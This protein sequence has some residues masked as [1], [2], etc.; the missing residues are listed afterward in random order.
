MSAIPKWQRACRLLIAGCLAILWA[1]HAVLTVLTIA[2]LNPASLAVTRLL[3][4]YMYP[5]FS[6]RWSLFSPN[7]LTENRVVLVKCRLVRRSG[8]AR[9]ETDWLDITT[10]TRRQGSGHILTPVHRV[11]RMHVTPTITTA[12]DEDALRLRR[13]ICKDDPEDPSCKEP[14]VPDWLEK[15]SREVSLRVACATVRPMIAPEWDIESVRLRFA[16]QTAVPFSQRHAPA[17]DR[18][19][20]FVE[21]DWLTFVRVAPPV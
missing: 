21:T 13:A 15:R 19:I 11:L 18:P 8:G 10:A 1:N 16:T 17:P 9:Q 3:Q 12:P 20:K 7:P 4:A 6:Q 2:P 5:L 14:L